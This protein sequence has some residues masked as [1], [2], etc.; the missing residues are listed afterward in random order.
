MNK[1][2]W[3]SGAPD[4]IISALDII[5]ARVSV[6][7]WLFTRLFFF[8]VTLQKKCCQVPYRFIRVVCNMEL[9]ERA[10]GDNHFGTCL[11][12]FLSPL[13]TKCRSLVGES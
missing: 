8:L 6:K 5:Y 2:R 12:N 4:Q 9:A 13:F 10:T 11:F 3:S 7:K 1:A